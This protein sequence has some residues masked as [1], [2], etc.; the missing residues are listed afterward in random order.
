MTN[1]ST[2]EA[3][4]RKEKTRKSNANRRQ[5]YPVSFTCQLG[6]QETKAWIKLE[7][8]HLIQGLS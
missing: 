6:T 5:K 1:K 3:K 4:K 8:Y 7:N 2:W